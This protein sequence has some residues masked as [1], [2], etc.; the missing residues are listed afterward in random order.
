MAGNTELI[1]LQLNF[2]TGAV[3]TSILKVF[4]E[5]RTKIE[6]AA[7][8][9]S[10]FGR[11]I[12]EIA[13]TEAFKL[14]KN[15][16]TKENLA[17][18]KEDPQLFKDFQRGLNGTID[19]VNILNRAVLTL[20]STASGVKFNSQGFQTSVEAGIAKF[21]AL[22]KAIGNSP[23]QLKILEQALYKAFSGVG[24]GKLDI[25]GFLN[26]LEQSFKENKAGKRITDAFAQIKE[27]I[28]KEYASVLTLETP[29]IRFKFLND[30]A[31]KF[32]G[33]TQTVAQTVKGD[34]ATLLKTITDTVAAFS[35]QGIQ[36]PADFL[37]LFNKS[38]QNV[39][40]KGFEKNK[41]F[42]KELMQS[43]VTSFNQFPDL[44]KDVSSGVL[45]DQLVATLNKLGIDVG[46]AGTFFKQ[47]SSTFLQTLKDFK[48]QLTEAGKGS[49]EE[50]FKNLIDTIGKFKEVMSGN[51][52]LLVSLSKFAKID[53]NVSAEIL[54]A[55]EVFGIFNKTTDQSLKGIDG[56]RNALNDL[57]TSLK[58]S[59]LVN[60]KERDALVALLETYGKLEGSLR[61]VESLQNSINR[62]TK[63][64][65]AGP[66]PSKILRTEEALKRL[67]A[68]NPSQNIDTAIANYKLLAKDVTE[69][70]QKTQKE[71]ET[72]VNGAKNSLNELEQRKTNKS[73]SKEELVL[74]NQL[75]ANYQNLIKV[76]EEQANANKRT[77]DAFNDQFGKVIT[78]TNLAETAVKSFFEVLNSNSTK[79]TALSRNLYEVF[80][81]LGLLEF[82]NIADDQFKKLAGSLLNATK[83]GS[84][85]TDV[86]K[87]V[88]NAV[89][90][91]FKNRQRDGVN[92]GVLIDLD[93]IKNIDEVVQKLGRSLTK[94]SSGQNTGLQSVAEF[95]NNIG[96]GNSGIG[97]I[98]TETARAATQAKNYAQALADLK[99][100]LESY[101]EKTGKVANQLAYLQRIQER[102]AKGDTVS[103]KEK[104][105]ALNNLNRALSAQESAYQKL[106]STQ[107]EV[108]K[109]IGN[110]GTAKDIGGVSQRIKEITDR[111]R[112]L[113]NVIGTVRGSEVF[114]PLVESIK[115]SSRSVEQQLT[116]ERSKIIGA[117]AGVFT[118]LNQDLP[119]LNFSEGVREQVRQQF[120][121][122]EEALK[123]NNL[124]TVLKSVQG[125]AALLNTALKTEMAKLGEGGILEPSKINALS[126]PVI[127]LVD[128]LEKQA[129]RLSRVLPTITTNFGA[130]AGD[131]G[132]ETLKLLQD[133]LNTTSERS[134]ITAQR[135]ALVRTQIQELKDAASAIDFR[136]STNQARDQL[137]Q[138]KEAAG[139]VF[140]EFRRAGDTEAIG[141]LR[142]ELASIT[143]VVGEFSKNSKTTID[144][145]TAL[146]TKFKDLRAG[147]PE[148][149]RNLKNVLIEA[150][151]GSIKT[152]DLGPL[153]RMMATIRS[154][155]SKVNAIDNPEEFGRLRALQIEYERLLVQVRAYNA[156]VKA[157]TERGPGAAA[158]VD[159]KATQAT[160]TEVNRLTQQ[161]AANRQ[162]LTSVAQAGN[163]TAESAQKLARDFYNT[164]S[165]F[166]AVREEA[167]K[168]SQTS[169]SL[170]KLINS[171]KG[172]PSSK[173][174]VDDL[175]K[176]RN[177]VNAAIVARNDLTKAFRDGFTG[178]LDRDLNR[179]VRANE[180]LTQTAE[181]GT[182]FKGQ[183]YFEQTARGASLTYE[184]IQRLSTALRTLSSDLGKSLS[185][186]RISTGSINPELVAQ[187]TAQKAAIDQNI[188]ALT[189][190]NQVYNQL[191]SSTK[192]EVFE[193]LKTTLDQLFT[194][195]SKEN[196]EAYR[197]NFETL[198]N[199]LQVNAASIK[200]PLQPLTQSMVDGFKRQS[201]EAKI[202]RQDLEAWIHTLRAMDEAAK[203]TGNKS[204]H[205]NVG[206]TKAPISA[207][208]SYFEHLLETVT[209]VKQPIDE[210]ARSLDTQLT[211]AAGRAQLKISE[212]EERFALLRKRL[213]E[214]AGNVGFQG[215]FASVQELIALLNKPLVNNPL[216]QLRK[217]DLTPIRNQIAGVKQEASALATQY[218]IT[219]TLLEG[220]GASSSSID[221]WK[222]DLEA[223]NQQIIILDRALAQLKV[224]E[225]NASAFSPLKNDLRGAA[226]NLNELAHEGA[227][228]YKFVDKLFTNL[229]RNIKPKID[230]DTTALNKQLDL[231][232]KQFGLTTASADRLKT[233]SK[234]ALTQQISGGA[235]QAAA[236][237]ALAFK[238]LENAFVKFRSG[239]TQA[240]MGFQMLGDAMLDPFKKAKEN[241]EQFSDT[242]GLVGAV[243]NATDG[244]F[245]A[246]TN[247]ALLMGATSRFTAE[248]AAEGLREL[249][250]AGFDAKE[251][252]A[253]LPAVMRLA[254]ATATEL[255]TAAQIAT[256]VMNEFRMDPEQFTQASDVIA[257]AANRTLATVEDLGFAFKYVGALAANI[258]ADFNDLT[259]AM[260]ALHNAGLKGTLA[261]TA[262]RGILQALHNP[263]NDETEL[264]RDLSDRL[265]GVGIQINNASGNFVGFASIL[266][267]LELSGITT[268]EV[269]RLFGQRAG[270]G[271]AALLAQGSESIRELE[272]NL[273][274]AEGTTAH[275]AEVMENTLKGR[276]L[277]MR[278]AFQAL[279]DQI[280]K[281][282]A[283]T[284][285][286]FANI[287]ADFVSSLVALREEFPRLA[288]AIDVG[289]S[290]IALFAAAL[291]SLAVTYAFILVPVRQFLA[292][293]K[294]FVTTVL[295][296]SAALTTQAG[297]QALAAKM[298]TVNTAA[299]TAEIRALIQNAVAN[300]QNVAAINLEILARTAHANVVARE[301]AVIQAQN[302]VN[303]QNAASRVS[304]LAGLK[305]IIVSLGKRLLS[306]G[307]VLKFFTSP[308][309]AILGLT[310]L[311]VGATYLHGKSARQAGEELN[312]QAQILEYSNKQ[313]K[314]LA[315]N[316][317]KT[318][319]N[320]N[321][322]KEKFDSL[323]N[324]NQQK[325]KLEFE[326]NQDRQKLNVQL[327]ELFTRLNDKSSELKD[328]LK[329]DINIDKDGNFDRF[330]ITMADGSSSVNLFENEL[331]GVND[332]LRELPEL[333]NKATKQQ[334]DFIAK[335]RYFL[336]I[337]ENFGGGKTK[338]DRFLNFLKT[339][340]VD[341][342]ILIDVDKK[343]KNVQSAI[344]RLDQIRAK[345]EKT[346]RLNTVDQ[347]AARTLGVENLVDIKSY[348]Q[349]R[350]FL[351]SELAKLIFAQKEGL[352]SLRN[353]SITLLESLTGSTKE[354]LS[355]LPNINDI[356]KE[357][358]IPQFQEFGISPEQYIP[359]INDIIKEFQR[360]DA[361]LSD[362]AVLGVSF[363]PAFNRLA[364]TMN[365]FGAVLTNTTENIARQLSQQQN[366]FKEGGD[367]AKAVESYRKAVKEAIEKEFDLKTNKIDF[368]F[369]AK[370]NF[371][372]QE[373][374]KAIE[375]LKRS[376]K[377]IEFPINFV[378]SNLTK[379][380]PVVEDYFNRITALNTEL[381]EY[382]RSTTDKIILLEKTKAEERLN[383]AVQ[384]Q[385]ATVAAVEAQY[386]RLVNLYQGD[387]DLLRQA[388]KQKLELTKDAL[389]QS[390]EA[391]ASYHEKLLD[392]QQKAADERKK[393][394]EDALKFQADTEKTRQTL[395]NI[396]RSDIEK[397]K[398]ERQLLVDL[399]GQVTEA[400][401]N[402]DYSKAAALID[403]RKKIIE[404]L[405]GQIGNLPELRLEATEAKLD[406]TIDTNKLDADLK[407]AQLTIK[408]AVDALDNDIKLP[409]I[410][411]TQF[412]DSISFTPQFKDGAFNVA[413]SIEGS[414]ADLEKQLSNLK[415]I[416]PST[417]PFTA[418]A[419]GFETTTQNKITILKVATQNA[420]KAAQLEP[421]PF[422]KDFDPSKG[423][424]EYEKL[425]DQLQRLKDLQATSSEAPLLTNA[426]VERV[427]TAY[428]ESRNLNGELIKRR[429]FDAGEFEFKP[430]KILST[431]ALYD[432]EKQLKG[433][434]TLLQT[435]LDR[436]EARS[437]VVELPVS[438]KVDAIKGAD[439]GAYLKKVAIEVLEY[440]RTVNADLLKLKLGAINAERTARLDAS[441]S[442]INATQNFLD[443]LQTR[444]GTTVESLTGLTLEEKQKYI[445]AVQS[446][447]EALVSFLNEQ[448][449]ATKDSYESLYNIRK[450]LLDKERSLQEDNIRAQADAAKLLQ[451]IQLT[452]AS[453]KEKKS[454]LKDQINDL[455]RLAKASLNLGN[456][457]RAKAQLEE[458]KKLI[459]E[460]VG[461]LDKKS[462]ASEKRFFEQAV[463]FYQKASAE[464]NAALQ[465]AVGAQRVEVEARLDVL[466]NS[467]DELRTN[468]ANARTEVEA[469]INK[470][471]E[472]ANKSPEE[473][474]FLNGE[475]NFNE[476]KQGLISTT[477]L[478]RI[479]AL[480]ESINAELKIQV[481]LLDKIT[482]QRS[483]QIQELGKLSQAELD[484]QIIKLGFDDETTRKS[485]I[486]FANWYKL[487]VDD[488]NR[489]EL[490]LK[491]KDLEGF[492]AQIQRS[493]DEVI[494]LLGAQGVVREIEN[495]LASIKA[496]IR[497]TLNL[498]Q[499]ANSLQRI[500]KPL[501]DEFTS[502]FSGDVKLDEAGLTRFDTLLGEINAR[503]SDL[504]KD[505]SND[506][507]PENLRE[508]AKEVQT[509]LLEIDALGTQY[510]QAVEEGNKVKI[511]D[512]AGQMQAQFTRL[513]TISVAL[514]SDVGKA[515]QENLLGA[516]RTTVP[517]F[518]TL[519]RQFNKEIEAAGLAAVKKNEDFSNVNKETIKTLQGLVDQFEAL[520]QADP[521]LAKSAEFAETRKEVERARQ[522][523]LQVTDTQREI[524]QN[525]KQQT[526]DQK[527]VT[528][529]T[530]DTV[531]KQKEQKD[532]VQNTRQATQEQKTA[533][534][535][536]TAAVKETNVEQ[537]KTSGLVEKTKQELASVLFG[538]LQLVEKIKNAPIEMV[539]DGVKEKFSSLVGQLQNLQARLNSVGEGSPEAA[540]LKE[541]YAQLAQQI[542]NVAQTT[543][544]LKQSY[545]A[546]GNLPT[547]DNMSNKL[548]DTQNKA[549]ANQQATQAWVQSLNSAAGAFGAIQTNLNGVGD[550]QT[551]VFGQ[552][553]QAEA[554]I[555][556][557]TK[558]SK[559]LGLNIVTALRTLQDGSYEAKISFKQEH[560][561][562]DTVVNDANRKLQ[563]LEP[564]K[565]EA[566]FRE[567]TS[568]FDLLKSGFQG[569]KIRL[570]FNDDYKTGFQ[571]I[572]NELELLRTQ[573]ESWGQPLQAEQYT[574]LLAD[575]DTAVSKLESKDLDIRI[576]GREE[577]RQTLLTAEMLGLKVDDVTRKE[578]SLSVSYA[579][580]PQ[581]DSA[582]NQVGA[583][584]D[585][586]TNKQKQLQNQAIITATTL[587][588][589]IEIKA[590][591]DEAERHLKDVD[592]WILALDKADPFIHV[593]LDGVQDVD[594][595]RQAMADL[596]LYENSKVTVTADANTVQAE[597]SLNILKQKVDE[598]EKE[599]K[600]KVIAEVIGEQ[601]IRGLTTLF[602]Q[603][604]N[605]KDIV[606]KADIIGE[607][608]V[609]TSLE[610]LKQSAETK[611]REF[612]AIDWVISPEPYIAVLQNFA[613]DTQTTLSQFA[614]LVANEMSKAAA[615]FN[616]SETTEVQA[617]FNLFETIKAKVTEVTN[618]VIRVTLEAS[619]ITE[620]D[621]KID[622]FIQRIREV[623]DRIPSTIDV[624]IDAALSAVS[625]IVKALVD[626]PNIK[627]TVTI[628]YRK[629]GDTSIDRNSGGVI[630]AIQH[631]AGGGLSKKFKELL[632]PIVPGAGNTDTVPAMLTPGEFVIKKERVNELGV[633]FLNALNQGLIQFKS[634]G[635][636]IYNAPINTLNSMGSILNPRQQVPMQT[637]TA[638]GPPVDIRL[639]IDKKAF[640]IKTPR[641]EA[642]KMVSAL[643]YLERGLKK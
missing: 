441:Q 575:M 484:A 518:T 171:L 200:D 152:A 325:L 232:Q 90:L 4:D 276:L 63:T 641:E 546:V 379:D 411:T 590:Q 132:R 189:A 254:Q 642:G 431:D 454:F 264:L 509:L 220:S 420:E 442:N 175:I 122:V 251:Q 127:Q 244:E 505:L 481:D 513:Q 390:Y 294:T 342:P 640:N 450:D 269:L 156:A 432:A 241:F 16:G 534:D 53:P 135:L 478:D 584:T 248:Q 99:K 100:Q 180:L 486:E 196:I 86:L 141:A 598:T 485:F 581:A 599:K 295:V 614:S 462:T 632:S 616:I 328:K 26:S 429:T 103:E 586:V 250:K 18:L 306:I 29:A 194:G 329:F 82:G 465:K 113:L 155:L 514:G 268:G 302:I 283:P 324:D 129:T 209:A 526:T 430:L 565:V 314:Q 146:E 308:L 112:E 348:E 377:V 36:V 177:E 169:T 37:D 11:A 374:D 561:T 230:V 66:D 624:V 274:S 266:E 203:A 425:T 531:D 202:A 159:N 474:E 414:I 562:I 413:K 95:L 253:T 301:T 158:I 405:A 469:L 402:E 285:I 493:F 559:D 321:A 305:G 259:A 422:F 64:I 633:G 449:S 222:Q 277:L 453:D 596:L 407:I 551:A 154:E 617:L 506:T 40:G 144:S 185:V 65:D 556:K 630:P 148:L 249:A 216:S 636:M 49:G 336:A 444:Y 172:D 224:F 438:F 351:T 362:Q 426:D 573:A 322:V 589:P 263:T 487:Q 603:L 458:Y 51:D 139:P 527:A 602:N 190:Y 489:Q 176:I 79:T 246:L 434:G 43:F 356:V 55:V 299:V 383:I 409:K 28:L 75:I 326:F 109:N 74:V 234:E 195:N 339:T 52:K 452:G 293:M 149:S 549:I 494:R 62:T 568:E 365:E 92:L 607:E 57:I 191:R 333:L 510:K 622:S 460:G 123:S 638:G 39:V 499:L 417:E 280:G 323:P 181:I 140:A 421:K 205:L 582:L 165:A 153:T 440:E 412:L 524:G 89:E 625:A 612:S 382:E 605:L 17:I 30:L 31:T 245:K 344:A 594:S 468:A 219:L 286:Y 235:Q 511:A 455:E 8:Q 12:Q 554:Y 13:G 539:P 583:S 67:I 311:I 81:R 237:L 347:S 473:F 471:L 337:Q 530:Q 593:G 170:D 307:D 608:N 267:Q 188:T 163:I 560:P 273:Q 557:L 463:E 168:L 206:D 381:L 260:A 595:A 61:T 262:L 519:V 14:F 98:I 211:S 564:A 359:I 35:S 345:F 558:E 577:L 456:F 358:L 592:E 111:S 515:Y 522:L 346:G 160:I 207:L 279:S 597:Q 637:Q 626:I 167:G 128:V 114:A 319:A 147:L 619:G 482:K 226:T 502:I 291:G 145:I 368:E 408:D 355:K 350:N 281:N 193:R 516:I 183:D 343:I 310:T 19:S 184:E 179:L 229:S 292:F 166:K 217:E 257:L 247:Q 312:K 334:S 639:T 396:F 256:I 483:Y 591:T 373:Y 610:N 544:V 225:T 261:G 106:L 318:T 210:A 204:L 542:F 10:L 243:T 615:S 566:D 83:S 623:P 228:L 437:S 303:A 44:Q 48:K 45:N 239:L 569:S 60:Q 528:K 418:F 214:G 535:T 42:V 495:K 611:S 93:K 504:Q 56:F 313:A 628:E 378:T 327:Q 419:K 212:L 22:N 290:G 349:A 543:D 87:N 387:A 32:S 34:V 472:L 629:T 501:A 157:G 613:T 258:G 1:N 213:A 330:I 384:Q 461:Q 466:K 357:K 162:E 475:L 101:D 536:V 138:L 380:G 369:E 388:E 223:V 439:S 587:A 116:T 316:L 548:S 137:A 618:T 371:K 497:P 391:H 315:I 221:R 136:I 394:E 533:Q 332:K 131:Q 97:A 410:D 364:S 236:Q 545:V 21:N 376:S 393:I 477:E 389:D 331:S 288:Q 73:F 270:P 576:K 627:R 298:T 606:I 445:S 490:Q 634:M 555:Q 579:D 538:Y 435:E 512:L 91:L 540:Q 620:A 370:L 117:I 360:L 320:L 54:K 282:L 367:I 395:Q 572:R 467:M 433:F 178:S 570:E 491:F 271:M 304:L 500:Q 272:A 459:S 265:G 130:S 297:A 424:S 521:E 255:S 317:Q 6:S 507:I 118:S 403:R 121:L 601:A 20:E 385:V 289:L 621:Q 470:L 525:Q 508:S 47:E 443:F 529:E 366:L 23:K 5:I 46:K 571:T 399:R 600:I 96:A 94:L 375:D 492:K 187:L 635:G 446:K 199:G 164:E 427:R 59:S 25:T 354:Q 580:L 134:V 496:E 150:F 192:I 70:F 341:D 126:L 401:A 7:A 69:A 278:S 78:R 550:T 340:F 352:S 72:A 300:G 151:S 406:F 208:I 448:V 523:L 400:L 233:A 110:F 563:D 107:Q 182:R 24:S 480:Q 479:K 50:G 567:I 457:D 201:Q 174:L 252:I 604:P 27:T 133:A 125:V 398:S 386:Q 33:Q 242:M 397:S 218:R 451:D 275:M 108:S 415:P 173:Q 631:F 231:V 161:L 520:E 80:S 609:L 197:R 68:I 143:K 58:N 488:L 38:L 120:S 142:A 498:Q 537:G 361:E 102:V 15:L 574:R 85:L 643:Q 105:T 464:N 588:N 552:Q 309:G 547:F 104:L 541:Q 88:Y 71:I 3:D 404:T 436:L 335:Q 84:G 76:Y 124:E 392:L 532:A 41:A 2:E 428:I 363:K 372:D 423:V 198:I 296:G 115:T 77:S 353:E 447:K 186:Q 578:I 9:A 416:I 553:S 476:S 240:A 119:K 338:S 215:T 517:Q 287:A 238:E 284:L 227:F 585:T 503:A